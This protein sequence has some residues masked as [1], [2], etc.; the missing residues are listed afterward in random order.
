MGRLLPLA[1]LGLAGPLGSGR[2]FWPWITLAD[3]VAALIHLLDRPDITGP[4]NLVGPAPARQR[5]VVAQ[6]GSVLHRPHVLP[7]P[8]IALKL[9]LGE[10]ASDILGSQRIVGEVLAASGFTHQHADLESA[11]NWL[12]G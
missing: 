11:V 2:Q 10:F 9:V 12:L 3:E 8:S 6:I 5:D 1:R 7:A 4:V